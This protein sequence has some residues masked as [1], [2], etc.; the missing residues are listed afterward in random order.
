M[1]PEDLQRQQKSRNEQ[2]V[3]LIKHLAA[4]TNL[5]VVLE[6]FVCI[7][8]VRAYVKVDNSTTLYIAK[9]IT[10]HISSIWRIL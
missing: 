3:K 10:V 8:M 4:I 1:N 2:V 5:T 6:C 9:N 7:T